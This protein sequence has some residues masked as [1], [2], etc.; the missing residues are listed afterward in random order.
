MNLESQIKALLL[1]TS[2]IDLV[3]KI[4]LIPLLLHTIIEG[5]IMIMIGGPITIIF[6]RMIWNC[7]STV[8]PIFSISS[9]SPKDTAHNNL[10]IDN[11]QVLKFIQRVHSRIS[12]PN[13]KPFLRILRSKPLSPAINAMKY[14][15]MATAL[16]TVFVV[17]NVPNGTISNTVVT[18]TTVLKLTVMTMHLPNNQNTRYVV[19][20]LK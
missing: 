6:T 10:E 17:P 1:I 12:S 3:L 14:M 18:Q 9:I 20:A 16:L 5:I 13:I 2:A 19:I 7:W 8:W 15:T 11:F 4:D